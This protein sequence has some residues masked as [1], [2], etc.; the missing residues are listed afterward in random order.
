M[1]K[2]VDIILTPLLENR[3]YKIELKNGKSMTKYLSDTEYSKLVSNSKLPTGTV[4][5]VE[6]T[7]K[8]VDVTPLKSDDSSEEGTKK[9]DPNSPMVIGQPQMMEIVLSEEVYSKKPDIQS[10]VSPMIQGHI[11]AANVPPEKIGDY[12]RKRE[13]SNHI[14]HS[15]DKLFENAYNRYKKIQTSSQ[16]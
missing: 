14:L 12:L 8:S 5:S 16:K 3:E 6:P 13:S 1:I 15:E 2:L 10:R 11:G 7:G 9:Y 4:K